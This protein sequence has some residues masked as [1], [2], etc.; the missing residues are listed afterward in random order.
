[1]CGLRSAE[2]EQKLGLTRHRE[3]AAFG[4]KTKAGRREN[5]LKS[6]DSVQQMSSNP[7]F[8]EPAVAE[9]GTLL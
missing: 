8:V 6:D 2:F 7:G 4:R 3:C 1:M 5:Q 9:A